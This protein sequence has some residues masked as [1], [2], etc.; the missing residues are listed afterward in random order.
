M[1][2]DKETKGGRKAIDK[3][4]KAHQKLH[5]KPWHKKVPEEHTPLLNEMLG[6]LNELGFQ[7]LREFEQAD[8]ELIIQELGFASR[9]GFEACATADDWARF[10]AMGGCR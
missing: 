6:E 5:A 7:S 10:D 1:A 9:E 3:Y 8:Q 2:A 4:R